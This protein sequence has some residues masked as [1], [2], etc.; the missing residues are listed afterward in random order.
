MGSD[1]KNVRLH[2]FKS[3]RKNLDIGDILPGE[4]VIGEYSPSYRAYK[5]IVISKVVSEFITVIFTLGTALFEL[6]S[7]N[8]SSFLTFR[9][10][11]IAAGSTALI[12]ILA[13]GLSTAKL[14]SE[15]SARYV[16]TSSRVVK[17]IRNRIKMDLPVEEIENAVI[18]FGAIIRSKD[19]A[20]F[21]PQKGY[22]DLKGVNLNVPMVTSRVSELEKQEYENNDKANANKKWGRDK[23]NLK[24]ARAYMKRLRKTRK[25]I[26]KRSFLYITEETAKEVAKKYWDFVKNNI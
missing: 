16:I 8:S 1:T 22:M 23:S 6:I 26:Y 13:V 12:T 2:F 4:K 9:E 24:I 15:F 7:F 11:I 19:Y 20:V 14:R 25:T 21:F 17:I 3:D 5:K 18:L 10:N